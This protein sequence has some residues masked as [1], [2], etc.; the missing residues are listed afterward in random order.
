VWRSGEKCGDHLST[1]SN[2]QAKCGEVG[3]EKWRCV[4]HFSTFSN[5]QAKCG[6]VVRDV[7]TTSPHFQ[8]FKPT[9]EKWVWR[10]G[11]HFTTFLASSRFS[12]LIYHPG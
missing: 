5:F 3:V 10:C 7:E 2:F 6:E 4:E 12:W 9:V 11:N 1:F 8:T